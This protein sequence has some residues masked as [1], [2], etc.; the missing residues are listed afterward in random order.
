M[1]TYKHVWYDRCMIKVFLYVLG[2]LV[3][4][5]PFVGVSYIWRQWALFGLGVLVFVCGLLLMRV[6]E[7]GAQNEDPK[8]VANVST[9]EEGGNTAEEERILS[10]KT[11]GAS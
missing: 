6:K 5:T 9:T 3:M 10:T 8:I 2:V 7:A 1:A 11:A 4:L